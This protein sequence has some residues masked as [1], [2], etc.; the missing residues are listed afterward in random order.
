MTTLVCNRTFRHLLICFSVVSFFGNGILQWQRA[1]FIRSYG[2][3]T[4]VLG[5]WFSMIYGVF[6]NQDATT[7]H[8]GS[9]PSSWMIARTSTYSM[10]RVSRSCLWRRSGIVMPRHSLTL[11]ARSSLQAIDPSFSPMGYSER[12]AAWPR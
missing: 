9:A 6:G 8:W 10:R 11:S 12:P 4:G 7:G 5:T 2:L 1:F 3:A